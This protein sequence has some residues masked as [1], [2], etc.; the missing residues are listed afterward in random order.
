[1]SCSAFEPDYPGVTAG[2]QEVCGGRRLVVA[3]LARRRDEPAATVIAV[4]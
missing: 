3:F 2:E 1:L 4:S